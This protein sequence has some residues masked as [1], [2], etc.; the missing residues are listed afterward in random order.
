MKTPANL[1]EGYSLTGAAYDERREAIILNY[2]N[3]SGS[4]V[5]RVSQQ[6]LGPDY[7]SIDPQAIV[8]IVQIGPYSGEYVAGGWMIPEAEVELGPEPKTRPTAT[9]M[10]WDA[11]VKL[12]TLRWTDGEFL[13]E[14][15]LAGGAEQ[16]G[17]LDKND[18]IALAAQMH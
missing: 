9:Q 16:P 7:Q 15:I 5:L 11:T 13:Y 14:I 4:L 18:L 1:P 17:Y 3:P 10:V 8:E 12:Q 2:T 6:Y